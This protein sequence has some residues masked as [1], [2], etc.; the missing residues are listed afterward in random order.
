MSKSLQSA[1]RAA[2]FGVLFWG[3]LKAATPRLTGPTATL[4][5]ALHSTP[6]SQGESLITRINLSDETGQKFKALYSEALELRKTAAPASSDPEKQQEGE[7]RWA[8]KTMAKVLTPGELGIL[9]AAFEGFTSGKQPSVLH[10]TGL[11]FPK[12][13]GTPTMDNPETRQAM[14]AMFGVMAI[15]GL[16]PTPLNTGKLG[17]VL[18][19]ASGTKG[20]GI[21]I[22][23][24]HASTPDGQPF[25]QKLPG[26]ISALGCLQNEPGIATLFLSP[27][28]FFYNLPPDIRE[29]LQ[30]PE[31]HV[32]NPASEII[33]LVQRF[34]L[35]IPSHQEIGSIKFPVAQK[36]E[37]GTWAF[38]YNDKVTGIGSSPKSQEAVGIFSR[39]IQGNLDK[40]EAAETK[41]GDMLV[42][43]NRLLHSG[44][45][46]TGK[47]GR[48]ALLASAHELATETDRQGRG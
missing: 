37:D 7:L 16:K 48:R 5:H 33:P 14:A 24:D 1:G 39:H 6:S 13:T 41:A 21:S 8:A 3:S 42:F 36:L 10:I 26:H 40:A 9:T 47:P 30:E 46:H 45:P 34:E 2:Q 15:G 22:H 12:V 27:K 43:D 17:Q 28:D 18:A 19:L 38:R 32:S 25:Y 44:G 29:A 35:G 23:T 31:F 11:P 4:N 20:S